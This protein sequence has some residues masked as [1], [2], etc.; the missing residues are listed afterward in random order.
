MSVEDF[1]RRKRDR[2]KAEGKTDEEID[3][4]E[5]RADKFLSDVSKARLA[6]AEKVGRRRNVDGT[7]KCPI[8]GQ[9]ESLFYVVHYN[10]HVHGR[11]KT[12]GCVSW[13]E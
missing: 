2:L 3:A 1:R 6:I 13:L 10:G 7:M 5:K 8:C 4:M 11:C 12:G 9:E